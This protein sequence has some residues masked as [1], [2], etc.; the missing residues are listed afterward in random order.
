MYSLYVPLFKPCWCGELTEVTSENVKL[1][2]KFKSHLID[3]FSMCGPWAGSSHHL[4][5]R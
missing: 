3:C 4:K 2:K 1:W 5:A